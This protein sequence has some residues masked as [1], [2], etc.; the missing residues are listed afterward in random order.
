MCTRFFVSH[1]A[2][3]PIGG[4]V[5][6]RSVMHHC[7]PGPYLSLLHMRIH[8]QHYAIPFHYYM[9]CSRR[10]GEQRPEICV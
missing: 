6:T 9:F 7:R 1:G 8:Y 4:D 2:E 10:H 5:P 3:G